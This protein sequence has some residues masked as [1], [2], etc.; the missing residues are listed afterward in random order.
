MEVVD[1][2][3][4]IADE[5]KNEKEWPI[6][7]IIHTANRGLS[8]ARNRGIDEAV[9]D[10][11]MFVDSDDWVSEDFCRIPY[12]TAIENQADMV[13]FRS[14]DVK[15]GSKKPEL[16]SGL[17]GIIN[18]LDAS[19]ICGSAVWRRLYRRELF[20]D[21]KFPEGRIYEDIA[22]THKLTHKAKKILC[23]ED[24]LYFH[25]NRN[26]SISNTH[27]E[28]NEKDNFTA[29]LEKY[30]DMVAYGFS[31][32]TIDSLFCPV[33]LQYLARHTPSNDDLYRNAVE[34]VDNIKSKPKTLSFNQKVALLAWKI[35]RRLFYMLVKATGRGK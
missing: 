10:W 24:F 23:I 12:E 14:Y 6:F 5:Y 7:R 18:E 13:I 9:A 21:I 8:A 4:V 25:L 26:G 35:D 11:L 20:E 17:T 1:E 34:Y 31:E 27:T 29:E 22:T 19:R 28:D 15:N 33:A 3:G 32:E 30:K 16:K 2:S